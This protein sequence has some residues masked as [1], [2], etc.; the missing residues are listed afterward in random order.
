MNGN[1]IRNNVPST[2][3]M[4]EER[5]KGQK[6]KFFLLFFSLLNNLYHNYSLVTASH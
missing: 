3:S 2:E 6:L 1:I 5:K 4:R